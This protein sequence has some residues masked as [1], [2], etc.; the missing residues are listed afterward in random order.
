MVGIISGAG[1]NPRTIASLKVSQPSAAGLQAGLTAAERQLSDIV[2][3]GAT[4][5]KNAQNVRK[6][7]A[8]LRL[9]NRALDYFNGRFK[10]TNPLFT[11]TEV[12]FILPKKKDSL[13]IDV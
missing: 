6:L 3:I 8:Y 1:L 9:F 13:K 12:E 10:R 4:A 2:D 11:K 5:R 7:D